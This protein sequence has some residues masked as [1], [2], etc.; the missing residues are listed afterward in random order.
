MKNHWKATV[1]WQ[2]KTETHDFDTYYEI[3]HF[4]FDIIVFRIRK[5]SLIIKL[6]IENEQTNEEVE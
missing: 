6:D 3:V 1:I 4:I 2:D 5:E